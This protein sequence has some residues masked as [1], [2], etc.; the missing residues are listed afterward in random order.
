ARRVAGREAL[1]ALE[2]DQLLLVDHAVVVL[3]AR[4]EL[5]FLLLRIGVRLGVHPSSGDGTTHPS[6]ANPRQGSSSGSSAGQTWS[7]SFGCAAAVGCRSSAWKASA[8][9]AIGASRNG[10]SATPSSFATLRKLASKPS[11]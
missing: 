2:V 6:Y 11:V 4:V 9:A 10:S 5:A 1:L 8:S 3:V 7:S